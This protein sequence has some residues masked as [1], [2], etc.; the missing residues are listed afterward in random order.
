MKENKSKKT[1]RMWTVEE[2]EKLKAKYPT[3]D[4]DELSQE[5]NRSIRSL[6]CKAETIKVKRLRNNNVV[7]GRKFCSMCQKWH[8]VDKFYRNKAK[9][10]GYEYYCKK[11]YD[12]KGKKAK[13][14]KP[15]YTFTKASSTYK[16][17]DREFIRHDKR[18]LYIIDGV[19]HQECT[20]CYEI[21]PLTEFR[22]LA[23]GSNG[24]ASKCIAC[25]SVEYNGGN[26]KEQLEYREERLRLVAAYEGELDK[27][28]LAKLRRLAQ[29]N[30][31]ARRKAEKNS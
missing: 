23:N 28:A 24:K 12:R 15:K 17:V 3:S 30:V 19:G 18:Q 11:Y 2:I 6:V 25:H 31:K 16:R 21:L 4:L 5:L 9:L 22:D 29:K 27:E 20:G 1:T 26:M 7:E 8:S 10:D 14:E 13:A